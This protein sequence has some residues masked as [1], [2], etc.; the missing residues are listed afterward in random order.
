VSRLSVQWRGRRELPYSQVVS[1][2]RGAQ[3][4]WEAMG[5]EARAEHIA[6]LGRYWAGDHT[7][8][9]ERLEG[10]L[11]TSAPM[12]SWG[13]EQTMSGWT[14]EA[15]MELVRLELGANPPAAPTLCGVVL[16][17]TV[18]PAGLQSV[19]LALLGGSAVCVRSARRLQPLLEAFVDSAEECAP[20]L[21][22]V[23]ALVGFDWA[24]A[25]AADEFVAPLEV[26]AVHGSS[27]AVASWRSVASARTR[28]GSLRGPSVLGSER[29][30]VTGSR[31]LVAYGHR[32]SAAWVGA[33]VEAAGI[34]KALA[35]D[36]C[37]W[38]QSGCLSPQVLFVE[39]DVERATV[40]AEAVCAAL[41]EV[42]RALPM[43]ALEV[44]A[45]GARERFV[46]ARMVEAEVLRA[47]T[48]AILLVHDEPGPLEPG[49]G[50][51]VLVV[52][53][54]PDLKGLVAS[55]EAASPHLQSLGVAGLDAAGQ[56]KLLAQLRPHGLNRLCA[57]GEM[58]RPEL[59]WIHDGIGSMAPLRGL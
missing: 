55:L 19:V 51:R 7:A 6:E 54:T 3:R 23:L 25:L 14:P 18:P 43:G 1:E 41:P 15:L 34:A 20:E 30:P 12:L 33:G 39:G 47:A 4:S 48:G 58:Q 10:E 24:D 49:C 44:W 17:S 31:R 40:V 29:N 9:W 45:R 22:K 46:R 28:G 13:F 16:A 11:G 36:L 35:L 5:F 27:E 2:L 32:L 37:A 57:L 42:E 21:S 56:R 38:D 50:A 59:C 52:R 8:L 26:L 53:P